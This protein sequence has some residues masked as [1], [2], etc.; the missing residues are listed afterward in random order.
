MMWRPMS[1]EVARIRCPNYCVYEAKKKEE[2]AT[3]RRERLWGRDGWVGAREGLNCGV[4]H[5]IVLPEGST[6]MII[7]DVNQCVDNHS[8]ALLPSAV[9]S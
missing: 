6:C 8:N 9:V 7:M 2:V 5:T 1:A 3:E 4:I